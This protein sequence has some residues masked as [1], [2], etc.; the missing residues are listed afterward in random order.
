MN[1]IHPG[2]VLVGP[3]SDFPKL[4]R[5]QKKAARAEKKAAKKAKKAR[6]KLLGSDYGQKM[7]LEDGLHHAHAEPQGTGPYAPVEQYH[8]GYQPYGARVART[9]Y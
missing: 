2:H 8:Q 6:A 4:S 9:D 1:V 3:D 5:A 7:D